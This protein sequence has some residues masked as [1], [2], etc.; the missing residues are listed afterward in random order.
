MKAATSKLNDALALA[1][2]LAATSLHG[3]EK[4][5]GDHSDT[6]VPAKKSKLL[7]TQPSPQDLVDLTRRIQADL[8][9]GMGETL[10]TIGVEGL[11][12]LMLISQ[13]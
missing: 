3:N 9:E 6:S 2:K 5:T 1:Q 13:Y 11:Y 12:Y 7:Y 10:W 4:E 8:D